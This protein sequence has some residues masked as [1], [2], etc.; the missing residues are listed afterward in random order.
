MIKCNYYEKIG[1]NVLA[2]KE[3]KKSVKSYWI[4]HGKGLMNVCCC[5]ECAK[6]VEAT[7]SRVYSSVI[8]ENA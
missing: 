3:P 5:E 4:D 8:T 1:N 2:H 6:I 7:E